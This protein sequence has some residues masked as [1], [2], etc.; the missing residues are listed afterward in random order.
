MKN[1]KK[2][3][4]ASPIIGNIDWKLV[5][6]SLLQQ[7]DTDKARMIVEHYMSTQRTTHAIDLYKVE[8][9]ARKLKRLADRAGRTHRT[10]PIS[11]P[12]LVKMGQD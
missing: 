5:A 10:S 2:H 4:F 7:G 1:S 6:R 9:R 11:Q 3:Q 8:A 12:V